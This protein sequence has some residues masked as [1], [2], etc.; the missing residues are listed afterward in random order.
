MSDP[1]SLV[2]FLILDFLTSSLGA[3]FAITP[4]LNKELLL[5]SSVS[6]EID[7]GDDKRYAIVLLRGT[8][9]AILAVEGNFRGSC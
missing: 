4:D 9:S 8:V 3:C 7:V 6:K 2:L 1:F 5:F